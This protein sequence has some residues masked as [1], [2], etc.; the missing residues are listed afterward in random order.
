VG[1]ACAAVLPVCASEGAVAEEG[2]VVRAVDGDTLVVRIEGREERVR[3]LGVDTPETKHPRK[4]VEYFG[5][6]ASAFTRRMAEGK[7]VQLEADPSNTNRDRY[8]RLLRYVFLPDGTLLNAAIIEQGYGHAYTRFPF[9]RME[10]FRAL[11]RSAREN[12]RGLWGPGHQS[13]D[14]VPLDTATLAPG[15]G[16]ATVIGKPDQ[17]VFLTRTGTRYH[18]KG[19]RHLRNSAIPTKLADAVRGYQPCKT[20]R[21]PVLPQGK[22]EEPSK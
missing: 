20:C 8:G 19:C 10:E 14:T 21:A 13:L 6:E 7:R 5:K 1:L 17:E 16:P 11:E 12:D 22:G 9:Q 3:L 15:V 4:P 2:T 18:L